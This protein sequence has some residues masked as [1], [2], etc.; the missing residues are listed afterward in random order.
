MPTI[1]NKP[2]DS[3]REFH[4]SPRSV[5]PDG[6]DGNREIR[7]GRQRRFLIATALSLI[8]G[9]GALLLQLG[10]WRPGDGI[11]RDNAPSAAGPAVQPAKEAPQASPQVLQGKAE[12]DVQQKTEG[13][14]AAR[15]NASQTAMLPVLGAKDG[16]E[17]KPVSVSE[18]TIVDER[19]VWKMRGLP[20]YTRKHRPGAEEGLAPYS[21]G[22]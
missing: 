7:K 9:F 15:G 13:S 8:I 3:D 12:K 18:I 14:M 17:S 22:K 11:N 2:K 4:R 19:G 20:A 10:P 6:T 16:A 1:D 5:A 21:M